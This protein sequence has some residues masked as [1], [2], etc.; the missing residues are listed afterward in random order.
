MTSAALGHSV[1]PTQQHWDMRQ[2]FELE[3][4]AEG[5]PDD[6][7]LFTDEQWKAWRYAEKAAVR[8][9]TV[10]DVAAYCAGYCRNFFSNHHDN[11]RQA[12]VPFVLEM[13]VEPPESSV[14]WMPE[15][16]RLEDE[17]WW[18]RKLVVAAIRNAES[19]RIRAGLVTK[20]VS[21]ELLAQVT[22]RKASLKEWMKLAKL[23]EVHPTTA[24]AQEQLRL[25][26]LAQSSLSNPTVR[27]TEL[28][29]RVKG[30]DMFAQ[31][32]G[33]VGYF[34]TATAASANHANSSRYNGSTPREVHQEILCHRWAM[35][36]A[37]MARLEI[38]FYGL[39]VAEPHKDGCPHWHMLCWFESED[40][41]EI[42]IS[43]FYDH[44]LHFEGPP[45]PG[46]IKNRCAVEFMDPAKGGAI[47]YVSKYISKNVDGKH[48]DDQHT[49]GKS[50]KVTSG[51]EGARR[52]QAWAS[53]WGIRQFQFFGGPEIGR[54][55][56][57]RRIR[58]VKDVPE[59]LLW[60]WYAAD[61]GCFFSYMCA[62][63]AEQYRPEMLKRTFLQDLREIDNLYGPPAPG[64]VDMITHE[65]LV[66]LPTMNK[67][68]EPKEIILGIKAGPDEV[69]T[70]LSSW[71]IDMKAKEQTPAEPQARLEAYADIRAELPD[72]DAFGDVIQFAVMS[73]VWGTQG[74]PGLCVSDMWQ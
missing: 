65:A 20:Y 55:R 31:F 71:R 37:E 69:L 28:M 56:E 39:R 70:R 22:K 49:D 34:L 11:P 35:F 59:S 38:P 16:L 40:A 3:E 2:Q 30:M 19:A 15:R 5:R 45:E 29:V 50:G 57:L 26:I 17:T 33:H 7:C 64:E 27:R 43:V 32:N 10:S 18:V 4:L 51:E 62:W 8:P 6:A 21:D 9:E 1:A 52:V 72:P 73:G 66:V 58:K 60:Y 44:Y 42:A 46:A 48:V 67:Y 24:T 41:A 14:G 68:M 13:G 63:H 36:R 47:A 23:T 53:A 61:T 12:I 25:D 74:P 54:W